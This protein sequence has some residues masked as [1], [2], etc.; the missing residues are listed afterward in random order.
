M[1]VLLVS[2]RNKYGVNYKLVV[3]A[4][5]YLLGYNTV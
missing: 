3:F 2:L 4:Y 1:S 5:H